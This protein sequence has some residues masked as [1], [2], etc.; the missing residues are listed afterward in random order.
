V[1]TERTSSPAEAHYGLSPQFVGEPRAE[2]AGGLAGKVVALIGLPESREG[3]MVHA[4]HMARAFPCVLNDGDKVAV[5]DHGA[6]FDLVV[7]DASME[8]DAAGSGMPVLFIG[9]PD[10]IARRTPTLNR[11]SQD[12]L[13]TPCDEEEFLLRAYRLVSSSQL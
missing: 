2:M 1:A 13:M 12:C 4:L 5:P 7:I 6:L 10:A 8:W 11:T 3:A 9:S